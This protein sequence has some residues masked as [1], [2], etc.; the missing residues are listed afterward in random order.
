MFQHLFHGCQSYFTALS[1]MF[2][3]VFQGCQSCVTALSLMFQHVFQGCQSCVTALSLM[4]Q[5]VFQGCQSCVTALSLMFQHVFQGCQSCVTAFSLMFQHLFQVRHMSVLFHGLLQFTA[6]PTGSQGGQPTAH[7]WRL[8]GSVQNSTQ[9]GSPLDL[10]VLRC[11]YVTQVGSHLGMCMLCCVCVTP[12]GSHRGLSVLCG[13][14][15]VVCSSS[16]YEIPGHSAKSA[17]GRLQWNTHASY[18]YGFKWSETV[19]RCMVVWRPQNVSR[20]GSS[21]MWHQPCNKKQH[22]KYTTAVDIRK[23][24]IKGYCCSF[25]F[26]YISIR[27][28]CYRADNSAI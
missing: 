2:Q 4:F 18:V 19:N 8:W 11:V 28:V 14:M 15:C 23:H 3:H 7:V 25:G 6:P 26:V 9:V 22:F 24:S 13:C 12:V 16:T 17:G 20:V 5:H 21:F 10:C 27:W 1:L